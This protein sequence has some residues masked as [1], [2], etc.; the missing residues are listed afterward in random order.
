MFTVLQFFVATM[1]W[2]ERPNKWCPWYSASAFTS[3][4]FRSYISLADWKGKFGSTVI[5]GNLVLKVK[6]FIKNSLIWINVILNKM[7]V[8]FG[9]I[10]F[11]NLW[12]ILTRARQISFFL[13]DTST[14]VFH[15]S[16]PI[17]NADTDIFA[18]LKL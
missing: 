8:N 12:Y 4:V 6:N 3:K 7:A 13:V 1:G 5:S 9:C 10:V 11:T 18:L 16:L 15:F 14:D 2:G 17:T